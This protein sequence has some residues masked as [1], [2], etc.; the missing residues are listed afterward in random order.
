MAVTASCPQCRG[1]SGSNRNSVASASLLL[2]ALMRRKTDQSGN[3]RAPVF[4]RLFIILLAAA[5]LM[6]GFA[7]EVSCAEE[8]LLAAASLDASAGLATTDE[9]SKK[10]PTVVEHCYTCAPV[11]MPA[12]VPVAEPSAEPVKLSFEAPTFL[13]EDYPGLDTPPPKHLT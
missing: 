12:L 1:L 4:R 13:L 11:V 7:G 3:V 6:V 9:G 2:M 8:T 5:Y 10:T